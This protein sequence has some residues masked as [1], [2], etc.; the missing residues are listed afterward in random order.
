MTHSVGNEYLCLKIA[1]ASGF[2][3]ANSQMMMADGIKALA[4]ER[5]D[6]KMAPDNSWIMRLPQEDFCQV[7]GT[8]PARKYEVDGGPSISI[9]MQELLGDANPIDDRETFMRTQVLF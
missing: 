5:F 3:T 2:E 1:K 7:S 6:R 9:I 4:V 8:S